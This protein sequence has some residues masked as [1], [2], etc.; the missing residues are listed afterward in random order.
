MP[1]CGNF[2]LICVTNAPKPNMEMK[3]DLDASLNDSEVDKTPDD[4]LNLKKKPES[5]LCS[6]FDILQAQTGSYYHYYQSIITTNL[7]YPLLIPIY[8]Y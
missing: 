5:G 3:I 7:S 2:G 1:P 6:V 4:L 8:H